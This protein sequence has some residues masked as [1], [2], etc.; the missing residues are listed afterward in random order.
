[1]LRRVSEQVRRDN[2]LDLRHRGNGISQSNENMGDYSITKQIA[3][4]SLYR[5]GSFGCSIMAR[6]VIRKLYVRTMESVKD[7]ISGMEFKNGIEDRILFRLRQWIEPW[8]P[9]LM[10]I[11]LD[12]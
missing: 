12:D 2:S 6:S 5:A 7:K 4:P 8:E 1:M 9:F 10:A 11:R 3:G